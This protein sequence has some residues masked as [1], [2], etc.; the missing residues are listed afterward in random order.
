MSSTTLEFD[1]G[2]PAR[3]G[4]RML[5]VV[6]YQPQIPPNTGNVG[7][8]CAITGCRLHLIHPL[9]FRITD[10]HLKRSGMD[11]W[12]ELDVHHHANW[13]EFRSA[14]SRPRRLWLFTTRG[15]RS[16]WDVPFSPDDGLV[17]GNENDGAPDWLHA[18]IGETARVRIPQFNEKLRSLN[19]STS[20]GIAVYEALRQL[21]AVNG[22]D[23]GRLRVT[24]ELPNETS[25]NL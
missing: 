14:T 25:K 4:A 17:F 5:H 21:Q 23:D 12:Y 16:L 7:R 11:Y 19:L 3:F 15:A 20:V 10:R 24:P 18:E 6:L 9:G 22:A 2:A 13:P 8:L 1:R